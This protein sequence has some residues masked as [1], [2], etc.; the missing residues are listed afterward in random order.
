[1]TMNNPLAPP[2]NNK[3][4]GT[5]LPPPVNTGASVNLPAN[6]GKINTTLNKV[7][8]EQQN[9]LET[10]KSQVNAQSSQIKSL[11]DVVFA[12]STRNGVNSEKIKALAIKT[13]NK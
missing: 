11:V 8:T 2:N 10:L 3:T 1:M 4:S 7:D 13:N 6:Q 5:M 12:L 9:E